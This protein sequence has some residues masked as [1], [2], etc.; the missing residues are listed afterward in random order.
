MRGNFIKKAGFT[1]IELIITMGLIALFGIVIANNLTGLFTKQQDNEYTEFKKTLENAACA[2]LDLTNGK[3][4]KNTCQSSGSV[5]IPISTLL[6]EGLIEEGN[7]INPQ[8]KTQISS[9][10]TILVTCTSGVRTCS[11]D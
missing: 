9:T 11:Y 7:L 1:L 10:K 5:T 8:T 3:A 2:Y 6:G 4:K